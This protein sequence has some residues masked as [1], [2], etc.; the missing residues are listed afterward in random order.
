MEAI[1]SEASSELKKM[2]VLFTKPKEAISQLL[3][4]AV[5]DTGSTRVEVIKTLVTLKKFGAPGVLMK[6]MIAARQK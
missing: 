5:D 1:R 2:E 3:A 4:H 6:E